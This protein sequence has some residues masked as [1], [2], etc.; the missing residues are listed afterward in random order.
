MG[1]EVV[2]ALSARGARVAALDLDGAGLEETRSLA[3]GDVSIHIV[4]VTS[5]EAVAEVADIVQRSYGAV[6]GVVNIAGIIH[7]FTPFAD[8]TSQEIERVMKVNFWGTV[9]VARAFLPLLTARPEAALV[10]MSSLSALVP[11]AGQTFYGASKGAVKQ[12][13]EGLY[14]ELMDSPVTVS[15][16]YPGNIAT[17]LAANSGVAMIDAKGQKV[18]ATSPADAGRIIV[19]GIARGRFRIIVG[20]DAKLLDRLV[21]FAPRWTTRV[22]A[23]RMKSVL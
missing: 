22:V 23:K 19:D 12:F 7:R 10:N 14:A 2:L 17:N 5:D 9:V 21:R 8:L 16:I 3:R 13:S 20:K 15:T 18:S 6:D 1:R 11:F 4:D